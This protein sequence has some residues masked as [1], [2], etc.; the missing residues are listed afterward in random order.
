MPKTVLAAFNEL[1]TLVALTDEQTKIA[2]TRHKSLRDFLAGRFNLSGEDNNPWLTGSYSR[3]TLIRQDRDIDVMAAFSVA[4]YWDTYRQNSSGLV[5]M[6][7]EALN[8][9]YGSTKVTSSGAAVV[10]E[11]SV[12]DVDVVPVFPR[13][14]GGYIVANGSG[15]WKATNPPFHYKLMQQRNAKDPLLKPLVKVMK[16]W[17]LC[18]DSLLESFHLEMMIEKMWRN[19]T[20]E[21][22]PQGA[23]E[24]LRVLPGWIRGA[25]NDPWEAGGR[26]DTYLSDQ[27]RQKAAKNAESDATSSASAE[28]LRK[29]GE[30]AAAEG[31]PQ[32]VP[33]IRIAR[34]PCGSDGVG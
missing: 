7:R 14:G 10:M 12:F 11:M 32:A 5:Y 27:D 4:K 31:I 25:V 2:S 8:K 19:E 30:D 13:D 16:Y 22:H 34:L 20:I 15:G 17:N 24:T 6:V 29:S 18:N 26:I 23:A 3:Q 21:S 28:K 33:R 9:E 1:L